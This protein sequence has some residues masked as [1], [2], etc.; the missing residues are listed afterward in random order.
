MNTEDYVKLIDEKPAAG[1]AA[2]QGNKYLQMLDDEEANNK[3]RLSASVNLAASSNP[4][5]VARQKRLAELIGAPLPAVEGNPV[6]AKRMAMQKTLEADTK[7]APALQQKYT[8][9]DFAKLAH[10]QSANL[11][12]VERTLRNAV[13][14]VAGDFIG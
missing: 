7:D 11:G 1:M 12:L 8:D 14:G 5:E 4:D 2:P 10:D 6:M 9:L 13:A 3:T